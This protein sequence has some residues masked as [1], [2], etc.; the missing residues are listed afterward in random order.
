MASGLSAWQLAGLIGLG[1]SLSLGGNFATSAIN[2][3]RAWKY[4]QRA[5]ALQ[6]QYNRNYTRDSY[7]L[8][9]EG[10]S[11]AGYNPLLATGSSAN[12][13]SP[14]GSGINSDSDNGSQA[15]T[16]ATDALR[17]AN[18]TKIANETAKKIKAETK[19]IETEQND[20]ENKPHNILGN[21]LRGFIET[22]KLRS[23]DS[24]I[25][26]IKGNVFKKIN[27]YKTFLN[28]LIPESHSA[29]DNGSKVFKLNAVYNEHRKHFNS[30]NPSFS[31]LSSREIKNLMN[32]KSYKN[33]SKPPKSL[34]Y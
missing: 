17:V 7:S 23:V 18:E 3:H 22:G 21:E 13:F 9:R 6:D 24:A 1:S 27:A 8:M 33:Y 5:M 11:K 19:K 32:K 16:S 31:Q 30:S 26:R 34:P 25:G 2:S 4:A 12:S 29:I 28:D 15:V 20:I 14:S 10:L